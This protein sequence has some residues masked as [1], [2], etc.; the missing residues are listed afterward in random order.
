MLG[1]SKLDCSF[2]S[3]FFQNLERAGGRLSLFI[4]KDVTALLEYFDLEDH[5]TD[6]FISWQ[7]PESFFLGFSLRFMQ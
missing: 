1:H 4:F 3:W 7:P 5:K 2:P 6:F